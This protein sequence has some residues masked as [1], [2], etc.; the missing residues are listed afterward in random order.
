MFTNAKRL[1]R[2]RGCDSDGA[3]HPGYASVQGADRA[4]R[5]CDTSY[6]A[7]SLVHTLHGTPSLTDNKPQQYQSTGHDSSDSK[8]QCQSGYCVTG[9]ADDQRL[10]VGRRG[11]LRPNYP[12]S[13][14]GAIGSKSDCLCYRIDS[15]LFP[16]LGKTTSRRLTGHIARRKPPE[17]ECVI[18][19]TEVPGFGIRLYPSGQKRWVVRYI[20][21]KKARQ[22]TVG[23]VASMDVH[24]ARR[25][26]RIKLERAA[27][28]GL[29]QKPKASAIN[30]KTPTFAEIFE[31]FRKDRPYAWKASTEKSNLRSIA[32]VFLP[33]FGAIP[34][35]EISK[36]D[37]N[38]WQDAMSDRPGSCNR[39]TANLA[40]V[41]NMPRNSANA[42]GDQIR[43]KDFNG[44]DGQK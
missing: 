40:A 2:K 34:I 16:D 38:A 3:E 19:D 7:R 13:T 5:G 1:S 30:G 31:T 18:W 27:V 11:P 6:R 28:H 14:K 22:E 29:P 39:Q 24:K 10:L 12:N 20:E 21:R 42:K 32:R 26:A 8:R 41:L 9:S 25:L 37:V 4:R 17:R 36:A 35:N 23:D 33:I 44:V 43:R 15:A